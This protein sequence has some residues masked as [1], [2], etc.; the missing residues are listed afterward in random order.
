MCKIP[1]KI[2]QVWIGNKQ[3]P[4]K[5]E[6]F[7]NDIKN[8]HEELGYKYKLW[9]NDCLEKYEDD[10]FIS[11]YL[12][13]QSR[14]PW[15]F[16]CDRIRL[17]ILRDEG[18]IYLD[19]DCEPIKNFNNILEKLSDN[20]SFFCGA[21]SHV[22]T[23]IT[24]GILFEQAVIGAVKNSRIVNLILNSYKKNILHNA[25]LHSKIILENIEPDIAIFNYKKFYDSYASEEAI[26]LHD[27]HHLASWCS[28]PQQN[29]GGQARRKLN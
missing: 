5:F 9:N 15:A 23:L 11:N 18:G 3:I 24:T 20:I 17:L 16:I 28:E 14:V 22:Q 21:R 7:A 4:S 25:T 8:I 12:K 1:K 26:I 10:I 27:P 13:K 6:S 29:W 19:V 2:H